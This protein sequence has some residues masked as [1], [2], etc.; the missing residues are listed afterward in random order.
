MSGAI[1]PVVALQAAVAATAARAGAILDDA[2]ARAPGIA[3]SLPDADRRIVERASV[4]LT[5]GIPRATWNGL[6]DGGRL[7]PGLH[8]ATRGEV[9]LRFAWNPERRALYERM[10]VD[11]AELRAS[12]PEPIRHVAGAG[13]FFGSGKPR[14]GDIDL[15]VFG[16]DDVDLTNAFNRRHA[17]THVYPAVGYTSGIPQN[18]VRYFSRD[19]S[20]AERGMVLLDLD[21]LL[22]RATAAVRAS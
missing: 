5:G 10:L 19:K 3:R 2:A 12:S 11:L 7:L 22:G 15:A 20:Q 8:P 1:R 9:E 13:S 21:D 6:D 4:A 17:S 14:P 18:M 16:L